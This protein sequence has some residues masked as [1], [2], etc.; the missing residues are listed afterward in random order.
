M[1]LKGYLRDFSLTQLLNL[2]SLANKTG[3][4]RLEG[5]GGTAGLYFRDGQLIDAGL[6]NNREKDSL[7]TLLQK[8][9]KIT[10]EQVRTIRDHARG[11]NDKEVGLVLVN[12]GYVTQHDVF[13]VIRKHH[14]DV[15][16]SLFTWRDG[17]FS[18][19]ANVS[20]PDGHI[21]VPISLDGII[22]EG[23]RR[24]R[25]WELLKTELPSLDVTLTFAEE[26]GASLQ[27]IK[28]SVEEWRVISFI[29]PR[30]TIRQIARYNNMSEFQIRK[31]VT[32][33]MKKGLVKVAGAGPAAAAKPEFKTP[34]AAKPAKP[35]PVRKGIIVR[36][37]DRIRGL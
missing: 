13:Q 15:V 2:V 8:S 26:P 29:S 25:E 31:I 3:E 9:G 32:G 22:M 5:Q 20:P 14:L 4:L 16:Y 34:V 19:E 24:V 7:L 33:L 37:I 23:S 21:A 27:D 35:P 17:R 12:A 6:N 30:N 18:F 1:A 28:L 10:E 36:L 11:R